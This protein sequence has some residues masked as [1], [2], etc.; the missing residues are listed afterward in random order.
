MAKKNL[1]KNSD[2]KAKAKSIPITRSRETKGP[3]V[4]PAKTVEGASSKASPS[5]FSDD[6]MHRIKET[7]YFLAEERGFQPG[8]E[9]D[10]WLKAEQLINNQQNPA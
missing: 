1:Q 5:Q 8:Y 2:A 9:V 10:D 6:R 7:A 3:A 4:S